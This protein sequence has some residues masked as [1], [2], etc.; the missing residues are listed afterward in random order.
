MVCFKSKQNLETR[1]SNSDLIHVELCQLFAS[2]MDNL[3]STG[4]P[5]DVENS[6]VSADNVSLTP[7]TDNSGIPYHTTRLYIFILVPSSFLL[8]TLNSLC[9]LV[10][11]HVDSI[12]DT[13][14]V[15][16]RS[17]TVADLGVGIFL[18][19]P[20]SFGAAIGYWPFGIVLCGIQAFASVSSVLGTLL[21]LFL[22]TVDRYISVV[23]ALRYHSLVT[24]KRARIA[25]CCAWGIIVVM[26]S[27][28]CVISHWQPVYLSSLLMCAFYRDGSILDFYF[29]VVYSTITIFCLLT[30]LIA[31]AR[32]F[33]ITRRH[34]RRIHADNPSA[35]GGHAPVRPN[36]KTLHT[37]LIIVISA[38]ALSLIPAI[39][40]IL[41][42]NNK[43]HLLRFFL[44]GLPILIHSWLNVFIYYLRNTEF[45]QASKTLLL[46]YYRSFKRIIRCKTN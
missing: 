32:L 27:V 16:L 20:M 17:M 39:S 43:H 26:V 24:L 22:L 41:D 33:S 6:T 23:Y 42:V 12:H 10:L 8:L 38:L 19:V 28:T 5:M 3:N 37:M 21:S 29:S 31:Y 4:S 7:S 18:A 13:T 11:R 45:H 40:L 35:H 36:K 2:K 9:L 1:Y 25:V 15:F 44:L 14:K 34:A 30:V 46:S